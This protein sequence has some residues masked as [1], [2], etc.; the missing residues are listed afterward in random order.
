MIEI[1]KSH[2][3]DSSYFSIL[4]FIIKTKKCLVL[5]L[6]ELVTYLLYKNQLPTIH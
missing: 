3:E 5:I 6:I 4:I 2:E 1:V